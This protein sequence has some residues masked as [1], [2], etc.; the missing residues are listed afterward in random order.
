MRKARFL[1]FSQTFYLL[2][3][4]WNSENRPKNVSIQY[5]QTSWKRPV[6]LRPSEKSIGCSCEF[7]LLLNRLLRKNF[8]K[9][10]V[11]ENVQLISLGRPKTVALWIWNP[12][13]AISGHLV[14]RFIDST[15][16]EEIIINCVVDLQ[17]L[18]GAK[19]AVVW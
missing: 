6:V 14:V 8:L 12:R 18:R 11:V 17:C 13:A 2:Y 9:N 16:G 10:A 4:T 7:Y 5:Q 3:E 15:F 1:R 19:N